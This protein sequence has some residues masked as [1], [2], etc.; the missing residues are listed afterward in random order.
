MSSS[1]QNSDV[2]RHAFTR[3]YDPPSGVSISTLRYEYPTGYAV[4]EHAHGADQLLYA[5]SGVMQI[6]S[7]RSIWL[8]PPL[9]AVWIPAKA[10]HSILMS[11]AVSMRALYLRRG[12]VRKC[13]D[14]CRVL[15]VRPILR[16]LI[17]EAVRREQ[18]ITKNLL[19]SAY[20][21]LVVS[22]IENASV[23]PT[24]IAMPEDIR[25]RR[26]A[27]RILADPAR[28][29]PLK[30]LCEASGASL[31]TI[32]RIFSR[33]TGT[34]FETWRQ[35]AR[36]MR[37]I[38]CLVGGQSVKEVSGVLGYSHIAPFIAMFRR[39]FGVTPG[40]WIRMFRADGQQ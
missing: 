35:Q 38:E 2:L 19:H 25:G 10:P 1:R 13:A 23:M 20:K 9:F 12:L 40:A 15:H 5:A 39:T 26:I 8:I 32:Q 24:S 11:S 7:G 34:D 16:E 28:K 36:L 31:R 30:V 27:S 29:E 14:Q 4:T 17:L 3:E 22:E 33:E 21:A 18:L 37:A 6:S